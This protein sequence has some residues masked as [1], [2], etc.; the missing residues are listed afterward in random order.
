MTATMNIRFFQH[1]RN[2]GSDFD[3][4]VKITYVEEDTFELAYTINGPNRIIRR[5]QLPL[6]RVM[7]WV[8]NMLRLVLADDDPYQGI[9]L[10]TPLMPVTYFN[11]GELM[12][13]FEV[14][15]NAVMFSL[16]HWPTQEPSVIGRD[17]DSSTVTY[18]TDDEEEGE[19]MDDEEHHPTPPAGGE[20]MDEEEY[21]REVNEDSDGALIVSVRERGT[22]HLY[23]HSDS[24]SDNSITG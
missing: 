10:E 19:V 1:S 7:E 13:N 4:S 16:A 21:D 6:D 17:D 15:T 24:D 2:D 20:P 8:R 18:S 14:F 12:E 9:Q 11:V 3:D 22:H 23:F 5:I